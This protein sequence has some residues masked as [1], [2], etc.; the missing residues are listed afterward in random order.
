MTS[1]RQSRSDFQN[2]SVLLEKLDK[3]VRGMYK[4]VN[5]TLSKNL[6]YELKRSYQDGENTVE[7]LKDHIKTQKMQDVQVGQN[8]FAEVNTQ[9]IKDVIEESRKS[10]RQ[11][12]SNAVLMSKALNNKYK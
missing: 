11:A 4:G 1:Q 3:T 7:R 10:H 5:H 9:Q 6:L 8:S 12:Q 2:A